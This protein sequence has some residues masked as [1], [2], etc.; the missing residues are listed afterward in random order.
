MTN[1]SD[2]EAALYHTA[3]QALEPLIRAGF[4]S[5]SCLSPIGAIVME[6]MG[7]KTGKLYRVP[8]LAASVGDLTV[9]S[10]M[11]PKRS[12]WIR[13]LVANPTVRFWKR[14]QVRTATAYVFLPGLTTEKKTFPRPVR[15]LA[16][17]FQLEAFPGVAFAILA[18][19]R[20]A[21]AQNLIEQGR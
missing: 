2:L 15:N 20:S 13:N 18:P 17:L 12:Q 19:H 5:S 14:G 10:T 7:R 3:N 8:A 1:S 21:R 16:E 11:R 6:I 9:V 4:G